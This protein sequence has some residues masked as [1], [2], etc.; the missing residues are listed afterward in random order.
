MSLSYDFHL[1]KGDN[2]NVFQVVDNL[3][4][5]RSRAFQYDTLNRRSKR[6][7]PHT[8]FETYQYDALGRLHVHGQYG[9]T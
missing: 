8:E 1:S 9:R 6:T 5:S 2:G 7:L 4:S 3:D